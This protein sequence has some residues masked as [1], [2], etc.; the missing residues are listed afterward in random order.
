MMKNIMCRLLMCTV[1]L[2][3]VTACKKDG[4]PSDDTAKLT[5]DQYYAKRGDLCLYVGQFPVDISPRDL[6]P[7]IME[8]MNDGLPAQLSALENAG[9]VGRNSTSV[10]AGGNFGAQMSVVRFTITDLGNKFFGTKPREAYAM[11]AWI[12][13]NRP[14]FCYG[15]FVLDKVESITETEGKDGRK[16]AEVKYIVRTDGVAGW[17]SNKKIQDAFPEVKS[18]LKSVTVEVTKTLVPVDG[19]WKVED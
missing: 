17:T 19:N 6:N 13:V 11:G 5:L 10:S 2:L 3:A 16:T 14:E 18:L 12:D 7:S 9:L 4:K 1:C 15:K 8:I